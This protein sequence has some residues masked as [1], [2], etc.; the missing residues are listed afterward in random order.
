MPYHNVDVAHT[1]NQLPTAE[2]SIYVSGS[3]G[4][5]SDLKMRVFLL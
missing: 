5:Q 2:S 1:L 3:Y 4:K